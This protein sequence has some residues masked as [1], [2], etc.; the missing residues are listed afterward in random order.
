MGDASPEVLCKKTCFMVFL[1]YYNNKFFIN[2]LKLLENHKK[3][4]HFCLTLARIEQLRQKNAQ[5]INS[6]RLL[7]TM[8]SLSDS[9]ERK[10]ECNIIKDIKNIGRLRKEIDK[11]VS[12]DIRK[13]FRLKKPRNNQSKIIRDIKLLFE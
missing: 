13:L 4:I 5:K 6:N 7:G 12:K 9:E 8:N 11:N 2:L 1:S 3:N 10:R